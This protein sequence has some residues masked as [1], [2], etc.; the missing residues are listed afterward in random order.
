[1]VTVWISANSIL[2][3]CPGGCTLQKVPLVALLH[4]TAQDQII[5][6]QMAQSSMS[7]A[8]AVC[9]NLMVQ[10]VLLIVYANW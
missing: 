10:H 6:R 8:L 9:S 7:V 3:T 5:D 4:G 1:M 2:G